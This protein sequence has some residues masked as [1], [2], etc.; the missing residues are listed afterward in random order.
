[1]THEDMIE[2]VENLYACTAR[3]DFDTAEELYLSEDLVITEYD[4]LPMAGRYEGAGA[5]RELYTMV[6]TLVDAAGLEPLSTMTD[7]KE[8]L[9]RHLRITY[10]DPNLTPSEIFEYFRIRNG[11]VT[12]IL[13][14]YVDPQ[15]F[16]AAHK[17][18]LSREN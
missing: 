12:K 15:T 13:P 14:V 16:I 8:N 7:G 2:L 5:L 18:K 4:P 1:M 3:G 17:M 9:V 6:F 11:R 10:A